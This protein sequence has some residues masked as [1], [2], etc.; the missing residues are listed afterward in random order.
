MDASSKDRYTQYSR[1][2]ISEEVAAQFSRQSSDSSDYLSS[3][4]GLS[5]TYISVSDHS[6]TAIISITV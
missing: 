1:P 4:M 3:P 2:G 6:F 5:T